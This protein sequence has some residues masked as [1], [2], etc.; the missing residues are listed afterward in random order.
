[1]REGVR[2]R[3]NALRRS[4]QRQEQD[5]VLGDVVIEQ[6]AQRHHGRSAS[7]DRRV[8]QQH[9]V[10]LNIARELGIDQLPTHRTT[11]ISDP[12]PLIRGS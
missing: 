10:L 9:V 2:Q 5:A 4:N 1:V 8:H 7:A 12:S 11:R 3:M 6:Y